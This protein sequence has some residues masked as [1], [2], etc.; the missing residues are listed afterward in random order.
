M[1]PVAAEIPV[2]VTGIF[3]SGGRYMAILSPAGAQQTGGKGP[4]YI[5]GV[6]ETVGAYKVTAIT[7]KTVTLM[8]N[9]QSFTISLQEFTPYGRSGGGKTGPGGGM[10]QG[11]QGQ[12]GGP[13]VLP[14][15]PQPQGPGGGGAMQ[16][17][18]AGQQPGGVR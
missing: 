10:M 17:G 2:Q 4:N 14:P 7:P 12:Q 16:G 13:G 5:V 8:W 18:G 1:Q 9:N 11:G 3:Q 15:P 6:G